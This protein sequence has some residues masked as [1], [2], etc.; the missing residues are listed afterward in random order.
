MTEEFD[1]GP[2]YLKGALSLHGAAW[3]IYRQVT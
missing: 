2:I 1:A 3:D